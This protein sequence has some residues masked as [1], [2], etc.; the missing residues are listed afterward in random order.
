M[1]VRILIDPHCTQTSCEIHHIHNQNDYIKACELID[2]SLAAKDSLTVALHNQAMKA[3]FDHYL[4]R[5]NVTISVCHPEEMLAAELGLLLQDL[6]TQITQD[7]EVIITEELIEKAKQIPLETDE[8]ALSWMLRATLGSLWAQE[9]ISR[10]SDISRLVGEC[11]QGTVTSNIHPTILA[12][13]NKRISTWSS[14]SSYGP[15][16]DWLFSENPQRRAEDL[17]LYRLISEY[18]KAI[19]LEAL[20]YGGRWSELSELPNIE[21]TKDLVPLEFGR[22]MQIPA[23][24]GKVIREYLAKTLDERPLAEIVPCLSGFLA[25]E[26]LTLKTYLRD[27]LAS[28][29]LSWSEPLAKL[30]EKFSKPGASTA[31][32]DSL[33]S[34][35]PV[36]PPGSL[37]QDAPWSTVRLW[38]KTECLPYYAWCSSVGQVHHTVEQITEFEDWLIHSYDDITRTDAF[39]PYAVHESMTS[40]LQ[41]MPTL[42]LVVDGLS[43]E[44]GLCLFTSLTDKGIRYGRADAHIAAIPSITSASKPSL[45][46]GQL[47]GQHE[48]VAQSTEYYARMLADALNLQLSEIGYG[49]SHDTGLA[50]II[51]PRKRAYL[52]LF[53]EIDQQLHRYLSSEKRRYVI[54]NIIDN[55]ATEIA[56]ASGEF[57]SLHRQELGIVL[58]SDHGYTQLPGNDVPVLSLPLPEGSAISHGRVVYVDTAKQLADYPELI[59]IDKNLLGGADITYL[60]ARGYSCIGSKPRGA[61]HGGLT[62]QE[63]VVPKIVLDP[64]ETLDYR[65]LEA[66]IS[67]VVRRGKAKNPISILIHN[68]NHTA[69]EVTNIDIRL[70][71]LLQSGPF[72]LE[73][74]ATLKIK[75]F[76]DGANLKHE[77]FEVTGTI[78]ARMFG[79]R[80]ST[81]VQFMYDTIGAALID[82]SFEDD[83]DV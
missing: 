73:P 25:E 51:Q 76:I 32:V 30:E 63:V 54:K 44:D 72:H 80:Y 24:F 81:E 45:V 20:S 61:A 68:P 40:L 27:N 35:R 41:N 58:A 47:P 62:P 39:A 15:L 6:P 38:L 78:R 46:C 18:P 57:I 36:P 19:Q 77:R 12:L 33:R 23:G 59:R 4:G 43:W 7:P 37:K 48:P 66:S 29:D 65:H 69:I 82:Q 9:T 31:F 34:I 22:H 74:D 26:E 17:V 55:L 67:G 79:V 49:S 50:E 13:R 71:T 56:S 83:F 21:L 1:S 60:V 70:T 10:P 2:K 8:N 42:L 28:V 3:C 52:Y 53:N 14:T 11:L 5:R 75:G 64:T 16:L